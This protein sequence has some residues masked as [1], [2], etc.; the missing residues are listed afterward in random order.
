[1]I[2]LRTGGF[3]DMDCVPRGLYRVEAR[4]RQSGLGTCRLH[5]VPF[6]LL[7]L[8][9]HTVSLPNSD[10][11]IVTVSSGARPTVK[12]ARFCSKGAF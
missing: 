5:F 7:P 2:L 1:M 8:L 10:V 4:K 9:P 3:Y 6:E 11:R 12:Q